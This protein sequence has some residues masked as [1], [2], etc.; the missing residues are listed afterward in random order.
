MKILFV[1]DQFNADNNGTTISAKRFA[2]G[3]QELGHDVY[4][5]SAGKKDESYPNQYLVK[6][7]P[8]PIAAAHLVHS[9][10]MTF[11]R[12]TKKTLYE[13][14]K[15][16]DVVHFCTPFFLSTAGLKIAK[17]LKIPH[18]SAFHVQPENIT[19]SIGLGKS[20]KINRE[21]YQFFREHF[22]DYFS[23]IHCPSNFIANELKKN[24]YKAN[25]YVISNGVSDKFSYLKTNKPDD[26]KNKI[27]ITMV[28]RLSNEKRQ[29]IL[30]EAIQK[31]KYADKIQ[32]VL[33]GK[34]PKEKKYEALGKKLVHPPIISFF[35]Q[36]D[37][38]NLLG[39]T[40]I[41][42][43]TSDAEIEA[44]SCMEAC[45]CGRVPVIANSKF[46][47]TKQF[48]LTNHSL[49]VPGDSTDLTKKIDYWIEHPEEKN[50]LEIQYAKS[51]ENYRLKDSIKKMEGMLN[52]AIREYKGRDRSNSR[53][54]TA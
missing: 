52:D 7:I 33:A 53:E 34:G 50:C 12:P 2:K 1:I 42:V 25:L 36:D 43:H 20:Q 13:A 14:I 17:E 5:I 47:A 3:L 35:S 39:Y 23:H 46:S 38:L 37:L 28:G 49:F 18:T 19:Y 4:V 54:Y 16:V 40:D 30:I 27:I 48:A 15:N 22:Y 45:A 32:L 41:Y 21:I 9:Q 11:A 29:D 31:S 44:I 51:A 6:E 10:G 8:L 26:I 24:N